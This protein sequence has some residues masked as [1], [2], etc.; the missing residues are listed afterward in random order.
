[1]FTNSSEVVVQSPAYYTKMLQM[2]ETT[3]KRTVANYLLWHMSAVLTANM[4]KGAK[5]I[6]QKFSKVIKPLIVKEL[7]LCL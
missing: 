6:T 7:W 4:G 5:E 1:M 2:L 3:P